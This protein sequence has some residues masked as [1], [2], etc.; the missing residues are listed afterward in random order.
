MADS[1][2]GAWSWVSEACYNA[3]DWISYQCSA[4][5]G[6]NED[7]GPPNVAPTHTIQK[8]IQ[9][10]ERASSAQSS[11]L[12]V[13]SSDPM[14]H[15]PPTM[16]VNHNPQSNTSP[17]SPTTLPQIQP[18][19]PLAIPN[20]T[21]PP[22]P[23]VVSSGSVMKKTT[24]E[25]KETLSHV[26]EPPKIDF[27]ETGSI[28]GDRKRV[29]ADHNMMIENGRYRSPGVSKTVFAPNGRTIR[30][31]F[32]TGLPQIKSVE[33]TRSAISKS[34][35]RKST[36]TTRTEQQQDK[37]SQERLRKMFQSIKSSK[38]FTETDSINESIN[39]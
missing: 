21:Q 28:F 19:N 35:T 16:T 20:T 2:R 5:C 17:P 7:C 18:P 22:A 9:P 31:S 30:V 4:C 26:H 8:D 29:G 24:T 12:Q 37:G 25:V 32:I 38:S 13:V 36:E 1:L 6:K 3:W 33:S 11:S 15:S 27:V 10:K 23:T 34:Y 39:K 14:R